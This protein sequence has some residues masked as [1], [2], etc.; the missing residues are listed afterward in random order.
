[1]IERV[2]QR[3]VAHRI[4]HDR[5]GQHEPVVG[6]LGVGIE[7]ADL[8]ILVRNEGRFEF[9]ALDDCLCRVRRQRHDARRR[10]KRGRQRNG[11][12]RDQVVLLDVLIPAVID[13]EVGAARHAK[14]RPVVLGAEF[15]VGQEFRVEQRVAGLRGAAVEAAALVTPPVS[16]IEQRVFGDLIVRRQ[17]PGRG[18]ERGLVRFGIERR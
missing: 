8:E 6:R 2:D 14:D 3:H 13:A 18:M 11:L 12:D 17:R 10:R 7:R 5:L 4:D 9:E 15:D 1:M 16:A